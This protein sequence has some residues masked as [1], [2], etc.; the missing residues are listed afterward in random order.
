MLSRYTSLTFSD[1]FAGRGL[2]CL[3]LLVSFCVAAV[4]PGPAFGQQ[5]R[6]IISQYVDTDSGTEPKGVELWNVSG[7]AIDFSADNLTVNRYANGGSSATTE[8][9]LTSGTLAAGEVIVIGGSVLGAYMSSNAPSVAFFNDSFFFNGDDALEVVL[10]ETVQDV[11]GTIGSDPGTAWTGSGVSTADQNIQLLAS[12][13]SGN[14]SGFTDPSTRFETVSD[15]SPPALDGFGIAPGAGPSGPTVEF[16]SGAQTVSETDGTATL[17]VVLNDPDGQFVEVDVAFDAGSSSAS[18]GDIGSYSTQTVGFPASDADVLTQTVTV[19][20]TDD[21]QIEAT[22][23]AVFELANLQSFG[24]AQI[25]TVGLST[26]T[27]T[28]DDQPLVVN[29]ILADPALGL[30]G[31]ANGDGVRDGSEDEFVEI[32]NNGS[33]SVDLSG[34]TIEDGAGLRH[35]FPAGTVLDPGIAVTV[36]GGGSPT[37]IP[38]VVQTASDG[39]LG[40]NNSGDDVTLKD[41]TGN[42]LLSVSYGSEGGNDQS[43]TRDPDF[44]G[45]FT[46]HTQASSSGARYSPGET[47]E[48]TSLP[49]ELARFT[50]EADAATARLAWTTASETNNAGFEIQHRRGPQDWTQI[51]FVDGAGTTTEATTY[52]FE[53]GV[54]EPG[55]HAFRL[56]QIDVDGT[57]SLSQE[58]TLQ[59]VTAQSV[60]LRGPNP[61]RAGQSTRLRV[62][63]QTRQSVEAALFNV[64][65]QQV[66]VLHRGSVAPGRPLDARLSTDGLASGLYFVRVSGES[67]QAT[68]QFTVV[69]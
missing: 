3:L 19:P 10:G 37:G 65:G 29:E 17:T 56:R 69:R 61:L 32:Y 45:S 40:F 49:V 57:A 1:V 42:V 53:T 68:R 44:T 12:I 23:E 24:G 15:A 18:L 52:R 16:G 64:L 66:R 25:G 62:T 6:L 60:V 20:L 35:T 21:S 28:D 26:L 41:E 36:F 8:F 30:E 51:G 46:Q 7:S 4:A 55:T 43:L 33:A 13:S 59:V 14:P 5:D 39:E 67:F 47:I 50:V 9:T 22:E 48:G 34:Y 31:D 11:F 54:L 58:K 38:G 2:P 63:A 27:I